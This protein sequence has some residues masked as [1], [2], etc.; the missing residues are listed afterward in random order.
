[1]DTEKQAPPSTLCRALFK[2]SEISYTPFYCEENA[3]L[4]AQKYVDLKTAFYSQFS[5]EEL[6]AHKELSKETGY[7]VFMTNKSRQTEFRFQKKGDISKDFYI[8]W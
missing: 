4:M 1:M 7:I 3:Y 6:A 5:P 2:A 8:A